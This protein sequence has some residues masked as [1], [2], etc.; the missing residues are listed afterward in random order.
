MSKQKI[1]TSLIVGI[2]FLAL[3]MLSAGQSAATVGGPTY[4]E[5]L[6]HNPSENALYYLVNSQSGRGCPPIIHKVDLLTGT[7]TTV[8]S[9]SEIEA[10]YYGPG[11]FDSAAYN[12]MIENTFRSSNLLTVINLAAHNISAEVEYVGVHRFDEYNTAADFQATIFQDPTDKRVINF[13]GCRQDQE[14]NLRG[15]AVPGSPALVVVASRIGNCFEGGYTQED[16]YFITGINQ[17]VTT[18]TLPD[19]PIAEA[20]DNKPVNFNLSWVILILIIGVGLG[21]IIG[22]KL[23]WIFSNVFTRVSVARVIIK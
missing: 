11:A 14:N 1:D 20:P 5:R 17:S 15:Y 22:Y 6:S 23:K 8:V 7:D 16:L 21:Y 2:L 10:N 4:I 3:F 18:V 13:T 12:Q 9:C 19:A